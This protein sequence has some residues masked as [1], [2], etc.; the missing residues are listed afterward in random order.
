MVLSNTGQL[1]PLNLWYVWVK[2]GLPLNEK[3][4]Y[5]LS[6]FLF[7]YENLTCKMWGE[8][9]GPQSLHSTGNTGLGLM[10]RTLLLSGKEVLAA[11]ES[12][13]QCLLMERS[14]F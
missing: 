8:N 1:V 2:W 12:W 3:Q 7:I 14:V 4:N 10:P 9:D 13:N 5:H 6:T 11:R